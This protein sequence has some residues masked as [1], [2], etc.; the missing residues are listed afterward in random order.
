VNPEFFLVT[1][2]GE[3]NFQKVYDALMKGNQNWA[4]DAPILMVTLAHNAYAHN[5]TPNTP[6]TIPA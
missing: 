1:R 4:G 6:V 5:A 3:E 2:N